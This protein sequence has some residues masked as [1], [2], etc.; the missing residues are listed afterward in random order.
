[1]TIIAGFRCQGGIVVCSDTQETSGTAKRSVPKLQCF[2]GPVISQDGQ[3]MVNPIWRLPSAGPEM[4]LSSTRLQVKRG[5]LSD[6]SQ[7]FGKHPN[8]LNRSSRNLTESSGR[9][10]RRGRVLKSNSFTG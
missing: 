9:S 5:M 2:Q 10:I 3:G 4:V 8:A 1:M 7:T 6:M